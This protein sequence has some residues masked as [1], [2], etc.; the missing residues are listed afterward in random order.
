MKALTKITIASLAVVGI[1]TTGIY[2]ATKRNHKLVASNQ[3]IFEKG[4]IDIQKSP[5]T[6]IAINESSKDVKVQTLVTRARMTEAYAAA[7]KRDFPAARAE[8]IEASYKHKGTDAMNPEFGSLP[9]QAVYQAIV[10]LEAEGKKEEAAKEYR[11]FMEERKLSPLIHACARRLE[12]LNGEKLLAEDQ[13][14]LEA[15]IAE[16]EKRIRFET[17]VCGPKCLEKILPALGQPAKD[18]K[19][20]AK[21]CKTTDQGTTMEGLKKGCEELGLKPIG[22]E[23]NSKDFVNVDPHTN[24]PALGQVDVTVVNGS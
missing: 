19:Q 8:F 11:K 10:C 12:R 4:L 20:L 1:A 7:K 5:K 16:Q 6:Y 24:E 21:I 14:R 15:G 17:S 22:L 13:A 18:Y 23:L 3:P 9:D 2:F